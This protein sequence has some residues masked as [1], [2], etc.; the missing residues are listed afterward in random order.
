MPTELDLAAR[1]SDI[2]IPNEV[3]GLE[4]FG[5]LA[6]LANWLASTTPGRTPAPITRRELVVF[7]RT[8][9]T[10]SSTSSIT[11]GESSINRR[12]VRAVDSHKFEPSV[13]LGISLAD[14]AIDSGIQ[15][16]FI[17]AD[18]AETFNDIPVIVGALTGRDAASVT[19][20]RQMTDDLWMA[21]AARIRDGI[22][23][24][25]DHLADLATLLSQTRSNDLAALAGCILQAA[26][27]ATPVVLIGE[28]ALTAA[29]VARRIAYRS[30]DW[31][32]PAVDSISPAGHLAERYLDRPPILELEIDFH[33][34]Y[35]T[36]MIMTIPIIDTV[37]T[38]LGNGYI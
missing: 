33:A 1:F 34:D 7:S 18:N 3:S 37:L 26:N 2:R 6:P 29:L 23:A 19:P 31:V 4:W 27:R 38:L 32:L 21:N 22:H 8:E 9:E 16:L 25:R 15:L 35:L 28:A 5:R 12:L 20:R 24:A 13:E 10:V 36:P 30:R 14:Q 11:I 17:A